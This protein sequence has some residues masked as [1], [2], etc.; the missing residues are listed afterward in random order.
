MKD[1]KQKEARLAK[2]EAA[3]FRAQVDSLNREKIKIITTIDSLKIRAIISAVFGNLD[4]LEY[5]NVLKR[6]KMIKTN[7]YFDRRLNP[8]GGGVENDFE[9][10]VVEFCC[11]LFSHRGVTTLFLADVWT[12]AARA[13]KA[14]VLDFSLVEPTKSMLKV[15]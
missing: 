8:E 2:V 10:R 15:P 13:D 4:S 6:Y 12:S 5:A 14:P 9:V 1:I 7:K 3:L 11:F